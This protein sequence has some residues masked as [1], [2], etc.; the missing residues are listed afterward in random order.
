LTSIVD[1]VF[2]AF[3][4]ILSGD[5]TVY[6]V[7][8]RSL[9]VSGTA[10]LIATLW[11]VPIALFL[12]TKIFRGKIFL[13]GFFA[14]MIGIPT[15]GLGLILYLVFSK[16]GPLGI[17]HLLYTPTAIILGEAIL[18]T[19]LIVSLATHAIADVDPEVM[20]LAKT[21]GASEA[22][23]SIAVLK[24]A[25]NGIL[26]AGIAGFNRAIAELGIAQLVGGNISGLTEVLTTGI[27]LETA[28][29]DLELSIAWTIILLTAVFGITIAT[30]TVSLI[31]RRRKWPSLRN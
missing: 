7:T 6:E 19:P 24:E 17:L 25:S 5:P 16:A 18:I 26:L 8:I 22:R 10:V 30:L 11:S 2:K 20:S 23:A 31:R 21:L 13:T 28:R 3:E 1:G 14:A 9:I 15:V 29:G 27:A 12:G 4:L